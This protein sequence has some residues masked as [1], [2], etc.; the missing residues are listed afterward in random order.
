MARPHGVT[1][2]VYVPNHGHF[3]FAAEDMD[4]AL[5]FVLPTSRSALRAKV[6]EATGNDYSDVRTM[7][8]LLAIWCD[9]TRPTRDW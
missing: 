9:A 1:V 3:D 4:Y 8:E 7:T 6:E 2:T 5:E